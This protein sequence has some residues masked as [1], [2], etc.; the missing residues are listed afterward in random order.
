MIEVVEGTD[1]RIEMAN[2]LKMADCIL[3]AYRKGP[4]TRLAGWVLSLIND[5]QI[6]PTV[7]F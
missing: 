1:D 3:N 4:K 2:A 7:L 5:A 6:P